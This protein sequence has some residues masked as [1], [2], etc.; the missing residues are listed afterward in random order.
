MFKIETTEIFKFWKIYF[1]N[2][3]TNFGN[4]KWV[5]MQY[6]GSEK[7][8]LSLVN[9]NVIWPIFLLLTCFDFSFKVKSNN[10]NF[11]S[12]AGD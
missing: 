1:L 8:K 4:M 7:N 10:S 6:L 12:K 9:M 3:L 5:K 11:N 2:I